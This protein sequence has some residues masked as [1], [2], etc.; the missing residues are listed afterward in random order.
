MTRLLKEAGGYV[1][2]SAAAFV[3]DI[4]LLAIQVSLLGI[5][6]LPAA[7][8]AF[9]AGT[10]F[11][12]WASVRHIFAFRRV[13]DTRLEFGFFLAVGVVGLIVNLAAMYA[14][15]DG[16]GL[17]YLFAKLFA[18]GLTFGVNFGLRRLFLFSQWRREPSGGS[19]KE[20]TR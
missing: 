13:E 9:L 20:M 3:L 1:A 2:A 8:I 5:P 16:L 12:Y 4:G 11:V 10:V 17:H 7:A 14:F 15:V 6:Y 19:A 18:A